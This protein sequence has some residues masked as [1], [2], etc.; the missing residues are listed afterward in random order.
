MHIVQETE[1]DCGLAVVKTV[2]WIKKHI[3]QLEKGELSQPLHENFSG[4]K[5]CPHIH[6]PTRS[7]WTIEL[8]LL[9]CAHGAGKDIVFTTTCMGVNPDYKTRLEFYAH[10]DACD[11][12]STEEEDVHAFFRKALEMGVCIRR[13]NVDNEVLEGIL[14]CES[15]VAIVLVDGMVLRGESGPFMGHYILLYGF[16]PEENKFHAK[17]PNSHQANDDIDKAILH[18]A[19][20]QYGTDGDIVF[21]PLSFM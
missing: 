5:Y 16:N 13:M 12:L 8:V 11:G 17:D 6:A 3:E 7:L 1:W 18:R 21:V 4:M 2:L 14:E 19:R 15:H 9:L 20:S 10:A